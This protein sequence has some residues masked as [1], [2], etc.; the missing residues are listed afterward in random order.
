[1]AI[2]FGN[3]LIAAKTGANGGPTTFS[4]LGGLACLTPYVVVLTLVSIQP[5][6]GGFT[7]GLAYALG[8]AVTAFLLAVLFAAVFGRL[9][10]FLTMSLPFVSGLM[11][12]LVFIARAIFD[13]GPVAILLVI[14]FGLVQFQLA[15]VAR[16]L[17]A[18]RAK[19]SSHA[20]SIGRAAGFASIGACGIFAVSGQQKAQHAATTSFIQS[21]EQRR[22]E[23]FA[24]FRALVRVQGCAANYADSV[25]RGG[26]PATLTAMGP[27]GSNCL[28]NALATGT[29]GAYVV[30][31][32]PI[33]D[34]SGRTVAWWAIARRRNPAPG[35]EAYMADYTGA[36]YLRPAVYDPNPASDEPDSAAGLRQYS[37]SDLHYWA[38]AAD[39]VKEVYANTGD[40]GGYPADLRLI[41]PQNLRDCLVGH[42]RNSTVLEYY[43]LTYVPDAPDRSGR[44]NGFALHATPL[45][46]GSDAVLSFLIRPDS[47][48]H[49][50]ASQRRATLTDPVYVECGVANK[51]PCRIAK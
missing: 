2:L 10:G 24:A 37:A 16:R 29:T 4:L 42:N 33:A 8:A 34:S 22:S 20:W 41:H 18:A 21:Q 36:F 9:I 43:L 25:S 38:D 28:E 31:Y 23:D 7:L 26:Y 17:Q 44:I 46:Y 48:I 1:V 13:M 32:H 3:A 27:G 12:G 19:E 30:R 6:P 47:V 15:K 45:H 11:F 39:C 50:T 35:D 40:A 49:F 14:V 5:R 51:P